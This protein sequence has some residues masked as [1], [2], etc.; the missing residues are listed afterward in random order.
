MKSQGIS[1][2]TKSEHLEYV[3][4]FPNFKKKKSQSKEQKKGGKNDKFMPFHSIFIVF[5]FNNKG[6]YR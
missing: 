4:F 3:F 6:D 1:F 5:K 2:Q